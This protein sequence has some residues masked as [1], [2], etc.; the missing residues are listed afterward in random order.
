MLVLSRKKH[1]RI[2]I[3]GNTPDRIIIEVVRIDNDRVRI[4]IEAP[5]HVEIMRDELYDQSEFHTPPPTSERLAAN[6][7]NIVNNTEIRDHE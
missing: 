3:N 6:L 4:G 2:V 7:G 5:N 1:E